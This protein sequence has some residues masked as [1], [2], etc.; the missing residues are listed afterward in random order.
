MICCGTQ[1]ID[2]LRKKFCSLVYHYNNDK[3]DK[4]KK[5]NHTSEAESKVAG[6]T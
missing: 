4:I 1:N 2:P 3:C 5:M 6:L